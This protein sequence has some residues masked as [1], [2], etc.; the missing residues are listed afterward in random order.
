MKRGAGEVEEAEEA[1][2]AEEE[3]EGEMGGN[4]FDC[5][6]LDGPTRREIPGPWRAISH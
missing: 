1:G 2:E 6:S 4:R 3:E 5:P